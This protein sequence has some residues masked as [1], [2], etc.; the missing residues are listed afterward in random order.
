MEILRIR[1]QQPELYLAYSFSILA[2]TFGSVPY[3]SYGNKDVDFQGLDLEKYPMPFV[4][5]QEKIYTDILK[6]IKRG[7]QQLNTS[8]P[9]LAG[10]VI[11]NR[12]VSKNGNLQTL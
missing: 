8:E 2:D 4:C 1:L 7:S 6:R 9:G 12:D 5:L 10:D 3:W 11:Y